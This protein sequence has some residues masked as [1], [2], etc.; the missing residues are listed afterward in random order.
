VT[1]G[2]DP[3]DYLMAVATTALNNAEAVLLLHE[4]AEKQPQ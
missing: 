1:E 3:V 4:Y 2:V